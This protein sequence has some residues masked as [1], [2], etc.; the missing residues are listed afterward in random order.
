M[1]DSWD[2]ELVGFAKKQR[3]RDFRWG[4]TDCATLTRRSLKLIHGSDKWA[5]AVPSYKTKR[6]ALAA[7]SSIGT[8][9]ALVSS[10]GYEVGRKLATAGDVAVGPE[11]DGHGLPS[12]SILLPS[13]K[14]LYST[15][16]DGVLIV[17]KTRLPEGTRFFRYG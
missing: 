13:L 17:S 11:V 3:G 4:S 14:V 6:A 10:G 9:R 8:E 15:K 16:E 12:V 1:I 5:G 7:A 2:V